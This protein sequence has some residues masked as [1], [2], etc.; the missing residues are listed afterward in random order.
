MYTFFFAKITNAHSDCMNIF[1]TDLQ[2]DLGLDFD[3]AIQ[4]HEYATSIR[5]KFIC[6]PQKN[7]VWYEIA[8]LK[9][10]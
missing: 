7:F 10:Y 5:L 8:V 3:W 1:A 2:S 9:L 6:S 4:K